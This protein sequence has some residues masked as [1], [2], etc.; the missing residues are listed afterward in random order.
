MQRW[1]SP[2]PNTMETYLTYDLK[3]I[4]VLID[5]NVIINDIFFP[6]VEKTQLK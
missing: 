5:L 1:Q 6:A 2:I 3:D 4:V